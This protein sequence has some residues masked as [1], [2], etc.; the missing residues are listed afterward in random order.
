VTAAVGSNVRYFRREQ[1]TRME[2]FEKQVTAKLA[3]RGDR[4]HAKFLC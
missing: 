1:L 2:R 3:A 4:L